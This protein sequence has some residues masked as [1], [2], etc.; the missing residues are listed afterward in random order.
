LDEVLVLRLCAG[1]PLLPVRCGEVALLKSLSALPPPE[2]ENACHLWTLP[3]GDDRD[4]RDD[5]VS[6]SGNVLDFGEDSVL[7]WSDGW[8]GMNER[9]RVGSRQHIKVGAADGE[10]KVLNSRGPGGLQLSIEIINRTLIRTA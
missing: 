5:M 8:S 7:D 4:E 10:S 1:L 6:K 9:K 3:G 2:P